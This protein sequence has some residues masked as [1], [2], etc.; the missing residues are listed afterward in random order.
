MSVKEKRKKK[1]L[2]TSMKKTKE[3][4]GV[5]HLQGYKRAALPRAHCSEHCV[6]WT[7]PNLTQFDCTTP[8]ETWGWESVVFVKYL[9]SDWKKGGALAAE[10]S[11]VW[12]SISDLQTPGNLEKIRN[13]WGHEESRVWRVRIGGVCLLY[14]Y[15]ALK[16]EVNGRRMP[17]SND[18]PE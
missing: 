5:L 12:K 3:F 9:P 7:T 2:K 18:I 6:D 16:E 1:K 4:A 15:M 13:N 14:G 11:G 10:N 17:M 8:R